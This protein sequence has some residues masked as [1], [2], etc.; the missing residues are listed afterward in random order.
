MSVTPRI[1]DLPLNR[2]PKRLRLLKPG[3]RGKDEDR[4]F[5]MGSCEFN[6]ALITKELELCP[7]D[8]PTPCHGVIQPSCVMSLGRF[9]GALSATKEQWTIDEKSE[10]DQ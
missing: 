2:I 6:H 5:R 4:V 3:A 9:Q 1:G 8:R 7:D 10:V